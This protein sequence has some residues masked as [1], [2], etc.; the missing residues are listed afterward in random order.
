MIPFGFVCVLVLVVLGVCRL[1][2]TGR[3]DRLALLADALLG[4]RQW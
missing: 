2:G 1:I 4:G 3:L